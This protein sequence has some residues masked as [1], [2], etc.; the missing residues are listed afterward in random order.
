MKGIKVDGLLVNV[1]A[2]PV[3]IEN[4]VIL[5]PSGRLA[6]S[7]G[8]GGVLIANSHAI[9]NSGIIHVETVSGDIVVRINFDAKAKRPKFSG[10]FTISTIAGKF[11]TV[12]PGSFIKYDDESSGSL[13]TGSIFCHTQKSCGYDGELLLITSSGNILLE[14][15]D[16][17]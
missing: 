12:D 16:K 8:S 3:K 9:G 11:T 4:C 5:S 2:A 6:V 1:R 10:V 14:V 17:I 15:M 13:T 7:T